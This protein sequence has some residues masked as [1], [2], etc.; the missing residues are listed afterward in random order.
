M[1]PLIKTALNKDEKYSTAHKT[2]SDFQSVLTWHN[3]KLKPANI[4]L[5]QNTVH[6]FRDIVTWQQHYEPLVSKAFLNNTSSKIKQY[7]NV[8]F[9]YGNK[10]IIIYARY[11]DQV[12]TLF[13]F[14]IPGNNKAMSQCMMWNKHVMATHTK[15]FAEIIVRDISSIR[16]E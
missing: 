10:N 13:V 2:P 14:T 1:L 9:K 4:K 7:K 3:N 8:P 12:I 11:F 16:F 6:I 5:V 15:T